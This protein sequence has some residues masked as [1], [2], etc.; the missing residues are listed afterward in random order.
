MEKSDV[1]KM[2]DLLMP[3]LKNKQNRYLSYERFLVF[4][5]FNRFENFL[6][7]KPFPPIQIDLQVSSICNLSCAWCIGKFVT[8][9]NSMCNLKNSMS[10][11]AFDKVLREIVEMNIDGMKVETVM[12]SGLVGEPLVNKKFVLKAV[13]QLA[14]A[15]IMI[16]LFTNGVLLDESIWD[17]L[18]KINSIQVSLDGGHESWKMIKNPTSEE[19]TFELV[20]NNLRGLVQRKKACNAGTEINVGYTLTESNIG[21]L[22]ETVKELCRIGVDSVCI[23]QDITNKH[24]VHVDALITELKEQIKSETKILYMHDGMDTVSKWKCSQGCYYRYF[25]TTIGSDGFIYPCDYQTL[26]GC[27]RLGNIKDEEVKKLILRKN[28]MWNS[29]TVTQVN[30]ICPPFAEKINPFLTLVLELKEQYG[31]EKLLRAIEILREQEG[32]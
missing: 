9:E 15:G 29:G 8:S 23:K 17:K 22:Y 24:N 25:F 31:L 4:E 21:E 28:C 1:Y 2:V 20:M 19:Y 26:D 27:T 30:N 11:E 12:F 32:N 6:R 10:E 5:H 13:E 18:L 16:C 3:Y 7:E 14:P